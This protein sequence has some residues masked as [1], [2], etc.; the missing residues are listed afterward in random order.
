[1]RASAWNLLLHSLL[2]SDTRPVLKLCIHVAQSCC[3]RSIWSSGS[4]NTLLCFESMDQGED[5]RSN[6]GIMT[7]GQRFAQ[8][9]ACFGR[10]LGLGKTDRL[11]HKF[12][13]LPILNV[14]Q[15]LLKAAPQVFVHG[16]VCRVL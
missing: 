8:F 14:H 11:I 5:G 3:V 1:M 2:P 12:C 13:C 10:L 9:A 4:Q 16:Y 15:V 6:P 7:V